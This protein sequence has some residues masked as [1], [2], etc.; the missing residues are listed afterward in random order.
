MRKHGKL[1][2]RMEQALPFVRPLLLCETL[3]LFILWYPVFCETLPFFNGRDPVF[4]EALP[5]CETLPSLMC[6][7]LPSVLIY[8]K[9]FD[10]RDPALPC[11][12]WD[13]AIWSSFIWRCFDTRNRRPLLSWF[14]FENHM[15]WIC[16]QALYE[17]ALDIANS[18]WISSKRTDWEVWATVHANCQI[19]KLSCFMSLVM[20]SFF[21]LSSIIF[22]ISHVFSYF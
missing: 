18:C 14:S 4:C 13:P 1:G 21:S 16:P 9:M 7:T 6:E 10:G 20:L 3:T 5:F 19:L 11:P 8:L 17:P 22:P 15:W 2:K 12:L